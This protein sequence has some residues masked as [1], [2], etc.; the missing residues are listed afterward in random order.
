M[1]TW[2][3]LFILALGGMMLVGSESGMIAGL[4]A[5]TFGYGAFLLALLVYLGGGLVARYGGGAGAVVRDA[6]TWLALGLGLVTL[7][8]Y[9]NELAPIAARVVGELLPGTAMTVEESA[10][11]LTEVKIRKRLNGHFT[12]NVDVNGKSISMIV[13]TGAS[14]IVLT[15]EDAKRVGIDID[16][17]TFGVPVLT[18]NGRTMAARV[19]LG[20]VAIGP[21]DRTKVEALVAQ[22]GAL[23]QSLLGMSFLSRLRSYEF[24]GDYLTL[25][26]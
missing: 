14:S 10:G 4:D 17:M 26:G 23:S 15:P 22:P 20:E 9:K 24:S 16:G 2:V 18:A 25:R 3:A 1:T 13:D 6:V 11:G 12:A 19:W 5:T 21:L 7:Y 8:A